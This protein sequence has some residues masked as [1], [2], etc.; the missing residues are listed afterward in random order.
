[1]GSVEDGEELSDPDVRVLR[2]EV[3]VPQAG[4]TGV[5]H[6]CMVEVGWD[7]LDVDA[8]AFE[9]GVGG[10]DDWVRLVAPTGGAVP[11]GHDACPIKEVVVEVLGERDAVHREGAVRK[12]NAAAQEGAGA[13]ENLRGERKL[14]EK[15]EQLLLGGGG[16]AGKAE[17][18]S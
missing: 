5:Q 7:L 12:V 3:R 10:E 15:G 16:A 2:V 17:G 1:M 6:G 14:A 18:Q 9:R 13:G 8:E 4:H 11:C